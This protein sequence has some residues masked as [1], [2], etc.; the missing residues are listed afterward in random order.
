MNAQFFHQIG[1]VSHH[2]LDA[3]IE[4]IGNLL[5]GI[6]FSYELQHLLLPVAQ[7]IVKSFLFNFRFFKETLYHSIGY[8]VV[9]KGLTLEDNAYC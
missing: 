2:C 8:L 6:S 1:A 7:A 5:V 3:E 4:G 9:D